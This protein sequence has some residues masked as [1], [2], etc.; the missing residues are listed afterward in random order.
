MGILIFILFPQVAFPFLSA[1]GSGLSSSG[2]LDTEGSFDEDRPLSVSASHLY[3]YSLLKDAFVIPE[4]DHNREP[5][6]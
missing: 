4:I 2:S 3:H 5:K 6:L 1:A